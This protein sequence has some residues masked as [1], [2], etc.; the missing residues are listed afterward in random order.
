M[1]FFFHGC[2]NRIM[3]KEAFEDKQHLFPATYW[4]ENCLRNLFGIG[5]FC[6]GFSPFSIILHLLS[7]L[8]FG[9]SVFIL[10]KS[11]WWDATNIL[12]IGTQAEISHS[13]N[14]SFPEN[15]FRTSLSNFRNITLQILLSKL[16]QISLNE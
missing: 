15:L 8:L 12:S 2:W 13:I 16:H 5:L 4:L 9:K 10:I 11:Y 1:V 6:S 3:G 7:V 14:S